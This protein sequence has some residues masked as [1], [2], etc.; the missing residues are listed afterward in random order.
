MILGL[1][2]DRHR[3]TCTSLSRRLKKLLIVDYLRRMDGRT[4]IRVAYSLHS[5]EKGCVRPSVPFRS[6]RWSTL[7]VWRRS[8]ALRSRALLVGE[9]LSKFELGVRRFGRK[10]EQKWTDYDMKYAFYKH[11][12]LFISICIFQLS[13]SVLKEKTNLRLKRA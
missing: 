1:L 5:K 6:W 10:I 4:V 11:I 8:A 9:T 7:N 3:P 2:T 12:F 13:L